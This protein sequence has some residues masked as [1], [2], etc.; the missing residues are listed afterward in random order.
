M[1][2]IMDI[3][4]APTE[5]LFIEG[6]IANGSYANETELVVDAVRQLRLEKLLQ[7][8][9]DSL[10]EH[11]AIPYTEDFFDRAEDRARAGLNANQEP[12]PDVVG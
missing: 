3:H 5:K 1:R 12:N 9:E 2:N 7:E 8:G 11:G 10:R 6:M 4:F